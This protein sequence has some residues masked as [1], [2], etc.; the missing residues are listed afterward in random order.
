MPIVAA[1]FRPYV[2]PVAAI[3]IT[4]I[5]QR[6]STASAWAMEGSTMGCKNMPATT[7]LGHRVVTDSST[8]ELG[9]REYLVSTAGLEE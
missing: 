5:V 8:A 3:L 7:G 9:V 1:A 4:W 2:S 6:S